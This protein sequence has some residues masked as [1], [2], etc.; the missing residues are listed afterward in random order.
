[1]TLAQLGPEER[2][3][4]IVALWHLSGLDGTLSAEEI[5][6]FAVLASEVG[7]RPF[8][9]TLESVREQELGPAQVEQALQAVRRPAAQ[10]L[11]LSTL[12]DLAASDGITAGEARFLDG[13]ARRWSLDPV[14]P[15]ST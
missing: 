2:T 12:T 13:L 15:I 5:E 7:P 14:E 6:G 9:E 1:M 3:A 8:F 4:L 10:E 11:L